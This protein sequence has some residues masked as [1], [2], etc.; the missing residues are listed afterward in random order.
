[1]RY[2]IITGEK[3]GDMHAGKLLQALHN[4]DNEVVCSGIGGEYMQRAGAQLILHY[5]QLN[6]IGVNIVKLFRTL[7]VHLEW[8]KKDIWRFHPDAIILV[9]YGGFNLRIAK[10]AKTHKLKVFYYIPP[11]VWAWG[12][13]RINSLKAYV[14]W[15]YVILP[16]EN[17]FYHKHNF[18]HV[19]Y[20]GHPS[21][22]DIAQ[23]KLNFNSLPFD[24]FPSTPYIALLPGSRPQEISKILPTMLAIV[25]KLPR[26]EFVVAAVSELPA[27]LYQ[28]AKDMPKVKII[29]D[30]AYPIL[31]HASMAI[32]ASGTATLEA[33]FL[34]IPQLVVYKTDWLT[35]WF[36]KLCL[37]IKNISLVNILAGKE[38]VQELIQYQ[39]TSQ[40]LLHGVEN[41]IYN[42]D[43]REQQIKNYNDIIQGFGNQNASICTANGIYNH[44]REEVLKKPT[45]TRRTLLGYLGFVTDKM[46][47]SMMG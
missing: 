45:T 22:E 28:Q 32:V 34:Q 38:I 20:V 19:T 26:F 21:L 2:Y 25:P 14:D 17:A 27:G 36:A 6:F 39:F 44:I 42:N 35:Y 11:K 3:S 37:K 18:P 9:D 1:M 29:Y 43:I 15:I 30:Q 23:H 12:T 41:L 33:A 7:R 46:D 16:F 4:L 31:S 8:C 10:F 13:Q 5:K 40:H 47:Q 24:T